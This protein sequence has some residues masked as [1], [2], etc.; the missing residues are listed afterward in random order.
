MTLMGAES[1]YGTWKLNVAKS[2]LPCSADLTSETMKIVE[3]GP[4]SYRNVVDVVLKS[5]ETRHQEGA[6]RVFDGK[7]HAV[8]GQA[9]VTEAVQRVGATTHKITQ[10]KDGK[11]V[12]EITGVVSSHGKVMT[13]HRVFGACDEMLVFE[14]Q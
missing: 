4:D 5:G 2:K 12:G 1:F 6:N 10:K 3:T 11:V 8:P 13:N 7:D 9:G 14:R